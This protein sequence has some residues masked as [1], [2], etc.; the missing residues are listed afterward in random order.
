MTGA[1]GDGTWSNS[2]L[3]FFNYRLTLI[4]TYSMGFFVFL[5]IIFVCFNILKSVLGQAKKGPQAPAED[6]PV[7]EDE[8]NA[9][10]EDPKPAPKPAPK[11]PVETFEKPVTQPRKPADVEPILFTL[12]D[13]KKKAMRRPAAVQEKPAVVQKQVV[14]EPAK[15]AAENDLKQQVDDFTRMQKEKN[16]AFE[17]ML[18]EKND[19]FFQ[20]R[21]N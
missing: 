4:I 5:F 8:E 14:P 3:R 10:K 7:N 16:D 1:T 13:D 19:Q 12:Q 6:I 2:F 11:K 20:S 18:K 9:V 21:K 15:P 17:R